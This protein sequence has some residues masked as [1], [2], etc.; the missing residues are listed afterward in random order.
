MSC[1]TGFG[2]NSAPGWRGTLR[3]WRLHE[4]LYTTMAALA[5]PLVCSVHSIV[6]LDFAASLM[7]GWHETILPPYF[8]VGA[9]FS[10]FAMV[11]I[12][13]A[14]IRWGF[15]FHD[16]LTL[17]H[18][19]SMALVILAS[20]LIMTL[21]YATECFTGWYSG[22][23]AQRDVISFA[24]T[25]SYAPLFWSLVQLFNAANPLVA[26]DAPLHACPH[27]RFDRNPNRHV[28]RA[29]PD[30]LE[31]LVARLYAEHVPI[32]FADRRRLAPAFCT[33]R[34][35]CVAVPDLSQGIWTRFRRST[36]PRWQDFFQ[37][38]PQRSVLP[39]QLPDSA[40]HC[41]PICCNFI[42]LPLPIQCYQGRCLSSPVHAVMRH[43]A[44]PHSRRL[45]CR[46]QI[47]R[48]GSK[49]SRIPTTWQARATRFLNHW[50]AQ[51][52]TIIVRGSA[53]QIWR[54]G[55]GRRSTLLTAPASLP[56]FS[57]ASSSSSS[58]GSN[59]E[60]ISPNTSFP[61]LISRSAHQVHSSSS[62]F[63]G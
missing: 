59:T 43:R 62:R 37:R 20:S 39:W 24:F 30:H 25:G 29:H 19:D 27:C 17:K 47:L 44:R 46:V 8:V 3:Q 52:V 5:V 63:I 60:R 38:I 7:P 48:T 35:V 1:V 45:S 51:D 32:V 42:P 28:A 14:A 49:L 16:I 55:T 34:P 10:G 21:S 13:A 4:R 26:S 6:G 23:Q 15:G 50:V 53:H 18:I 57:L 22:K 9:L 41:S 40:P 36:F 31:H 12:L 56:Q 2:T 61:A 58:K 33:A 11:V 54:V